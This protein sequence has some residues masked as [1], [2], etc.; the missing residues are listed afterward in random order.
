MIYSDE[1]G[2]GTGKRNSSVCSFLSNRCERYGLV[3]KFM[4][5]G[6]LPPFAIVKQFVL[7]GSTLLKST[8]VPGRELIKNYVD[9]D[10]LSAFFFQVKKDL[11]DHLLV[12]PLNNLH[13]KCVLI[14]CMGSPFNYVVKIPN[15]YE[16]H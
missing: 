11:S 12:V 5:C 4:L 7:T 6:S 8:G 10:I 13:S 16:H 1:Y 15:T 9:V 14:E 2:T 3:K